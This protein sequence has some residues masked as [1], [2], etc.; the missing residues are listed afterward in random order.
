M[1][2]LEKLMKVFQEERSKL[3]LFS[4]STQVGIVR[5]LFMPLQWNNSFG[6]SESQSRLMDG[7]HIVQQINLASTLLLSN[8]SFGYLHSSAEIWV[9]KIKKRAFFINDGPYKGPCAC[10]FLSFSPFLQFK[11]T[12]KPRR[13]Q[14]SMH[15]PP[16]VPVCQFPVLRFLLD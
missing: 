5:T 4:R 2:V 9:K 11:V 1:K 10:S 12:G 14:S 7:Y 16:S 6:I 3:L 15:L 13:C 8:S